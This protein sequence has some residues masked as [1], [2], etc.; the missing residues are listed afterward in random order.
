[1]PFLARDDRRIEDLD[2]DGPDHGADA[3]RYACTRV[4]WAR[5]LNIGV[6]F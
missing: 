1:M 3:G 6:A 4:R 5:E 2:S